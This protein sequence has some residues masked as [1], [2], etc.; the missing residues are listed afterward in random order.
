VNPELGEQ[1]DDGNNLPCDGCAPDCQLEVCGN[2]R[3]DCRE[4]CDDGNLLPGDG[5][6]P[7]CTIELPPRCGN[8]RLERGEECDDGNTLGCDGCSADCRIE[9]CGDG[10]RECTE[11]C[12]DGNTLAC[13]GCSATCRTERCGDGIRECAEE[14][15]DANTL[16]CD[17]CSPTCRLERCGNGVREC[18][19]ECDDGNTVSGDGCSAT[20]TR[21]G[22]SFCGDGVLDPGE[23][24][25][26]GNNVSCDG[27]SQTCRAETC[28]NGRIDCGEQ[29]D[30]G[31]GVPNDG[32][33]GCVADVC[34][35]GVINNGV[36]TEQCE[37]GPDGGAFGCPAAAPDCDTA[38]CLC[39]GCED[40]SLNDFEVAPATFR[41]SNRRFN[42]FTS[43]SRYTAP[44]GFHGCSFG[45]GANALEV[46]YRFR[47]PVA[48]RWVFTTDLPGTNGDTMIYLSS[49][50]VGGVFLDCNDDS[51]AGLTSVLARQLQ[52]GDE[53]LVIV[54]GWSAAANTRQFT[55]QASVET[56]GDG[57]RQADEECDLGAAN[58][59][60]PAL[61]VSQPNTPALTIRPV[62]R[63]TSATAF[64]AYLSGS[65]HTGYED[66]GR[67]LAFLYRSQSSGLI[68][69]FVVHGIDADTS[70]QS[71]P[72]SH[73]RMTF[74]GVPA[75]TSVLLSDDAG[76][77]VQ[78]GPGSFRGD[79]TF[80]DNTDGGIIVNLPLPD[81]WS[82]TI[83]PEFLAGIDEWVWVNG[84]NQ[85]FPLFP[86]Q[87]LTVQAS[88]TR[89]ACRTNCTVPRCGD[90]ILDGGEACDDGNTVGGDGCSAL[91]R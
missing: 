2:G 85:I 90:G 29:C 5:C 33:T 1:C 10:I 73:V 25:D 69:L 82:F 57:L 56:C 34:G 26:D 42:S 9:R 43:T 54:D 79:W 89:S 12:D 50:C 39:W 28:G 16:A 72:A 6:S 70:G 78:L 36:G 58:T 4:Q 15:D 55:L 51:G 23:E 77:L 62:E 48:G 91:C 68:S 84:D 24:C 87:P 76:E 80:A 60:G 74:T 46:V 65:A 38:R 19:E 17:G 11:T 88:A 20:C 44:S 81:D 45:G 66:V 21:E 18:A 64:Y 37:V 83:A 14:C 40:L 53:L 22:V 3:L 71:Q 47:A 13:D 52:A 61:T 35:D 86:D 75:G 27:C 7:T 41:D 31:N 63:F 59:N 49:R 30:D 32:C 67:S 8:G